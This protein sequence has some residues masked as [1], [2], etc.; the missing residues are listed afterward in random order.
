MQLTMVLN[1]DKAALSVNAMQVV[2][3]IFNVT[4]MVNAHVRTAPEVLNVTCVMNS[5]SISHQRDASK[6]ARFLNNP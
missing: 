2:L 6:C 1:Q 5:S 4:R 3:Q